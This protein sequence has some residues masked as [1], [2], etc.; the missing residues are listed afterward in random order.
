MVE[1]LLSSLTGEIPAAAL[2]DEAEVVWSLEVVKY[3]LR[4]S[5]CDSTVTACAE[6]YCSWLSV[7]LPGPRT[8][9]IPPALSREPDQL[10]RL[11]LRQLYGL[12]SN[13]DS[14]HLCPALETTCLTVLNLLECLGRHCH[15]LQAETLSCL[16]EL[17]LGLSELVLSQPAP[18]S[19][20]SQ[21]VISSL[22][23]SGLAAASLS[24]FPGPALWSSLA[25]LARGWRHRLEVV[26]HWATL[27]SAPSPTSW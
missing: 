18:P 22:S 26:E 11:M 23:H 24:Q 9:R 7:L 20:L 5:P 15:L 13:V 3:G 16:L 8:T 6:L 10:A 4:L 25:H 21:S 12:F 1:S 19:A 17:L 2:E 14:R 27:N